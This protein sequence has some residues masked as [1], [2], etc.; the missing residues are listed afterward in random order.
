MLFRSSVFGFYGICDPKDAD[1][2]QWVGDSG[3]V[4]NQ[5]YHFMLKRDLGQYAVSLEWLHDTV[6]TGPDAVEANGNQ[7]AFSAIYKF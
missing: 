7:I 1:V 4:K 2:L 6:S 5:Q 3:R